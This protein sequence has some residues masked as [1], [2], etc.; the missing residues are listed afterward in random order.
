MSENKFPRYQ[1]WIP[2]AVRRIHA[3]WGLFRGYYGDAL[4]MEVLFI[5]QDVLVM[6][7]WIYSNDRTIVLQG[8]QIQ[9]VRSNAISQPVVI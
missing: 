2:F 3:L 7:I 6:V 8:G 5:Q 9:V 4:G 1:C